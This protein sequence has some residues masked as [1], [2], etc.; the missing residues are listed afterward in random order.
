MQRFNLTVPR[1]FWAIAKP[2]WFGEEKWYARGM[3]LLV[4]VLSLGYTGLSVVLNNQRGELISALSARNET[5]FWQTILIF[6]GVLVLYAPLY[7]GYVYLRDT[8]SL[9]WRQFVTNQFIDRYFQNRAFYHLNYRDIDNPDQRITEDVKSFTQESLSL[10]LALVGNF[11]AA[12][13]I[14]GL[15]CLGGDAD[16]RGDFWETLDGIEF[17]AAQKRS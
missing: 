5:R 8:L 10:L 12:D 4:V 1:Q 3:L 17:S 7:A 16:D 2:Y 9:R 15:L 14:S 11:S 13:F 6:T